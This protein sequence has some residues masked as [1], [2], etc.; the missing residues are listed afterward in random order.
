[1][2]LR[3][4]DNVLARD[5][6]NITLAISNDRLLTDIRNLYLNNSKTCTKVSK[7]PVT[8]TRRPIFS[9]ELHLHNYHEEREII[10]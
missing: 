9:N 10:K 6:F 7:T 3:L 4:I 2:S 5:L 8:I 1:M